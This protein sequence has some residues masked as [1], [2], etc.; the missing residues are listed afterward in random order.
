LFNATGAMVE[1]AISRD[2]R[3][4]HVGSTTMDPGGG[5]VMGA[6]GVIGVPTFAFDRGMFRD[7]RYR[8]RKARRQ[9]CID[10]A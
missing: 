8:S 9:T 2:D 6:R 5:A 1:P 4:A 3:A 10:Q 7:G